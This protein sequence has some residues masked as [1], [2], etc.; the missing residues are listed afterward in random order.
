[1]ARAEERIGEVY[2]ELLAGKSFAEL[3]E[4]HDDV[5]LIEEKERK[6][7]TVLP[8]IGS[9]NPKLLG[10]NSLLLFRVELYDPS[11]VSEVG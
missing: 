10:R 2:E 4:T 3:S 7:S 8:Y 5:K 6:L 11:K 1:M 9:K